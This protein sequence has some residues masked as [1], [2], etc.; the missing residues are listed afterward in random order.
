MD[1]ILIIN[2]SKNQKFFTLFVYVFFLSFI[3]AIGLNSHESS[4]FAHNFVT[5]QESN[6]INRT[7]GPNE[8]C[9][10]ITN[11]TLYDLTELSKENRSVNNGSNKIIYQFCKNIPNM[12]GSSVIYIGEGGKIIKLA[13]DING[14]EGNKNKISYN[15]NETAIILYLA[16]GEECLYD[17]SQNYDF[18]IKLI[19]NSTTNFSFININNYEPNATCDFEL[20][21]FSKYACGDKEAY[22]KSKF[23][24]ENSLFFG[25]GFCILGL[26]IGIFGYRNFNIAI[27]LVCIISCISILKYFI[28]KFFNV[29]ND[30]VLY[31]V[32]ILGAIIG[33][34]ISFFSIRYGENKIF[35][36]I[37][38]SA[39]GYL[40]G[41]FLFDI[42]ISLIDNSNKDLIYYLFL[43]VCIVIGIVSGLVSEKKTFIVGTSIVGGYILMRGISF[44][45]AN[46]IKYFD[47]KEVFDY[48]RTGNYEIIREMIGTKFYIYPAMWFLF[49]SVFIFLQI[50]LNRQRVNPSDDD[51]NLESLSENTPIIP[52]S[53]H[54]NKKYEEYD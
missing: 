1:K 18:K 38:S 9:I 31:E 23:L 7:L 40:I 13:G 22:S 15:S 42:L 33:G 35:I 32:Y 2:T 10:L 49:I 34:V 26:L 8:N 30:I 46:Y 5:F 47:E 37:K 24:D 53:C 3:R 21:A 45:L 11:Y 6:I 48:A 52:G 14:K 4:I 20:K 16:N 12:N 17:S 28:F 51:S 43:I 19:C 29:N 54:N 44:F 50:K 39:F 25:I 41:T 36:C 27:F